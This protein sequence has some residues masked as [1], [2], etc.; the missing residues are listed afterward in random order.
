[1]LENISLTGWLKAIWISEK[2]LFAIYF[3]KIK[4]MEFT[5]ARFVQQIW[6]ETCLVKSH[7]L[8]LIVH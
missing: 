4:I 2:K 3:S 8:T 1:M 7:S 6:M 5:Q